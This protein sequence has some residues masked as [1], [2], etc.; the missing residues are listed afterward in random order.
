MKIFSFL[1]Q[2][3]SKQREK[4]P[5][6][7]VLV[8]FSLEDSIKQREKNQCETKNIIE[9]CALCLTRRFLIDKIPKQTFSIDLIEEDERYRDAR[10]VTKDICFHDRINSNEVF[11]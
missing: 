11:R 2:F 4:K 9:M 3:V 8:K 6:V 1:S 5:I 10:K 7:F